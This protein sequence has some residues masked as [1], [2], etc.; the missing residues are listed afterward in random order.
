MKLRKL[1]FIIFCLILTACANAMDIEEEWPEQVLDAMPEAE[2]NTEEDTDTGS[3]MDACS[4]DYLLEKDENGKSRAGKGVFLSEH[5]SKIEDFIGLLLT[6]VIEDRGV[7]LADRKQYFS[8]WAIEQLQETDWT[9]VEDCAPGPYSYSSSYVLNTL[10]GGIGYEFF[11]SFYLDEAQAVRMNLLVDSNGLIRGINVDISA[12]GMDEANS[13][14]GRGGFRDEF[15]EAVIEEGIVYEGKIFLDYGLLA[16]GDAAA[17]AKTIGEVLISVMEDNGLNAEDYRESFTDEDAYLEFRD[18][19]WSRL[20][21]GWRANPYYDCSYID[22]F[23]ESGCVGFL[24]YFYPDYGEMEAETA[25]AVVFRCSVNVSDGRL[26]RT[27][28]DVYPMTEEEYFAARTWMGNRV[29]LTETGEQRHLPLSGS[30][31]SKYIEID[32]SPGKLLLD[33]LQAGNLENGSIREMLTDKDADWLREKA[34][35]VDENTGTGWKVSEAYR[36]YYDYHNEQA[37]R[38]HYRYYFYWE[39]EGWELQKVLVLEVWISPDGIEAMQDN[40]F[41]TRDYPEQVPEEEQTYVSGR[42]M[43]GEEIAPFLAF[44]WT[45]DDVLWSD[46]YQT[47]VPMD[48]ARGWEFYV[49]DV[50]FDGSLEMLVS[51]P[52]NHCGNNSLYL[53]KQDAGKVSHLADT[54]ATPKAYIDSDVDYEIISPYLDIDL[55]DAYADAEGRVKYLSMDYSLFGGSNRGGVGTLALY[56]TELGNGAMPIKVVEVIYC[57]PDETKEMYFLGNRVYEMGELS[58]LLETYMD[59]YTKVEIVYGATGVHFPRDIVEMDEKERKPLLEELYG[60]LE[61]LCSQ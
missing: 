24:Y 22:I 33:D 35:K 47:L 40:W 16:A 29:S 34:E 14:Y 18:M 42:G 28:M 31:D 2:E 57:C 13:T 38:I 39:K 9:L 61:E 7:V 3:N 36:C 15:Q 20:G 17:S 55:L 10:F 53:Y 5:L 58:R 51:F 41:M 8:D 23:Q 52:A 54:I 50:D 49:A 45:E 1:L 12:M 19:G 4:P 6:E 21:T 32:Y 60:A 56:D 59:G 25:K 48:S 46:H 30:K 43:Q 44:D 11:Y 26:S 37:G 27:E